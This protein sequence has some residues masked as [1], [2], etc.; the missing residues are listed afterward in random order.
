VNTAVSDLKLLQFIMALT[1]LKDI[2]KLTSVSKMDEILEAAI[3]GA[4]YGDD[5]EEAVPSLYI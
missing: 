1:L 5:I 2:A 4:V 3:L